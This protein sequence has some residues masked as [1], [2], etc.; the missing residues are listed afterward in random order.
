TAP[1]DGIVLFGK[2]VTFSGANN[3]IARFLR[4]RLGATDNNGKDASELSNGK[5]LIF[6]HLSVTWGM[7]EVFSINWDNKGNNPDNITIQNSILGQ[8][9]HRSNHSA[10][11]LIQPSAGGKISLIRNLYTSNKTRNPK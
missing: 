1:G 11:G 9:L 10:G 3:T 7:D 2:R 4:I 5:N 8:G 6:D